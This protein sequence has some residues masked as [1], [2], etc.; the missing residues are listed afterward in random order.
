[1]LWLT[2]IWWGVITVE[3]SSWKDFLLSVQTEEVEIGN[4]LDQLIAV[5]TTMMKSSV[6][7]RMIIKLGFAVMAATRLAG[8]DTAGRML[9]GTKHARAGYG[10]LES[11][12]GVNYLSSR[13]FSCRPKKPRH[14]QNLLRFQLDGIRKVVNFFY[15]FILVTFLSES[16]VF[17]C[18]TFGFDQVQSEVNLN[19]M[20]HIGNFW[21][22]IITIKRFNSLKGKG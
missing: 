11:A 13:Q 7:S 3:T 21:N 1:V 15:K 19:F 17:D 20:I 22:K 8:W 2:E 18:V 10:A 9:L 14:F 6:E 16:T 4:F 12:T 5:L